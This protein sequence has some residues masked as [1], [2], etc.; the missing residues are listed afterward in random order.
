MEEIEEYL[1]QAKS[2]T[3][4]MKY[5]ALWID[6]VQELVKI[7]KSREKPKKVSKV[8]SWSDEMIPLEVKEN[9]HL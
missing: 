9:E 2:D 3:A 7:Q 8:V 6:L 1:K 5:L 4:R